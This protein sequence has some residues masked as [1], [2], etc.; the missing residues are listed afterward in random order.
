MGEVLS[1]TVEGSQVMKVT[2]KD[3]LVLSKDDR[4]LFEMIEGYRKERARLLAS[5]RFIDNFVADPYLTLHRHIKVYVD[6]LA[7][8]ALTEPDKERVRSAFGIFEEFVKKVQND[9]DNDDDDAFDLENLG[10]RRMI[11]KVMLAVFC[12]GT[13]YPTK[14][15]EDLIGRARLRGARA[16]KAAESATVK[17]VI[18]S[19]VAANA[20]KNLSGKAMIGLAREELKK[21]KLRAPS[22]ATIYRYLA[23]LKSQRSLK[24]RYF[25]H[26]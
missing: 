13:L 25:S 22:D 7:R 12:I 24:G 17:G 26:S 4:A 1:G 14:Q 20:N 8:S 11:A 16:K 2:L 18:A 6:Q 21:K 15:N 23:E 19:V 5:D 10:P 9:N 3:A